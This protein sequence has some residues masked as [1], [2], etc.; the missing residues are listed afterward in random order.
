MK[1]AFRCKNCGH[2]EESAQAGEREYPAA[3]RVCGHGVSFD[4]LTG[5]KTYEDAANWL[6]LA[7]ASDAELD[8]VFKHHGIDKGDI[9]KHKPA[10]PA[11]PDHVPQVFERSVTDTQT[12]ED[13][14]AS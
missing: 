9:V 12:M 5:V 3:C 1:V 10:A 13:H 7:D 11:D 8:K 14:A 6:V 2:L 4:P